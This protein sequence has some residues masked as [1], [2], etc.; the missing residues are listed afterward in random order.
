MTT[1]KR[2]FL[3]LLLAGSLSIWMGCSS[4]KDAS[5]S[6]PNIL[7]I[8]VDDLGKEWVTTYG[9]ENI[10]TPHI[11]Q[12]A[13]GGMQFSNAYV[14]P[15]C[16][17]TRLSFLTGQYPYRHGWVNHW[18]VPRWGG[19]CHYDWTVNPCISMVMKEAG[20]KSAIAGKWQI[21]DF[22]VQPEAMTEIGFDDYCMWTGGE[23]NNPPSDERFWDPYIHTKEG[24]FIREGEYGE[25][26]FVDFLIDFMKKHKDEPMFLYYPMVLTHTPFVTTPDELDVETDLDK[27]KAMVRYT[28]KVLGKTGTGFGR[29]ANSRQHNHRLD[30]R[31]WDDR[32]HYRTSGWQNRQ[33]SKSKHNGT[34]TLCSL[35]RQRPRTRTPRCED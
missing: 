25:T 13:A 10:E 30:H 33:R 24:S 21:N 5:S 32:S 12:L 8:L 19:G 7:F 26:M 17:P 11:D 9:G 20:Y 31:Q 34:G 18:D 14:M 3:F 27:H 28:D 2:F 6:K 23:G 29:P 15:Q 35:H 4:N 22:R 1:P 16:T